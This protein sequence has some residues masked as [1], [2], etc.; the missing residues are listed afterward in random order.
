MRMILQRVSSASVRVSDDVVASIGPGLC[1]FVGVSHDDSR[2]DVE[3]AVEKVSALRVFADSA[4]K[5][6]L[7]VEDVAGEV[8]V[9]SQFTLYGDLR[10]GRRPS[11]SAAAAPDVAK[12]LID[13]MVETFRA[14]GLRTSEGV[15]GAKMDVELVNDGPVTFSLQVTGGVVE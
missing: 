6:N 15:F 9:V 10:R 7:S 8:L 11:F 4:G 5:M 12:P 1:L 14:R 3:T 2:T 13:H